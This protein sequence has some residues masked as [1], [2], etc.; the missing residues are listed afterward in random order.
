[1]KPRT[2]AL[3]IKYPA[4]TVALKALLIAIAFLFIGLVSNASARGISSSMDKDSN[5][6]AGNY[7]VVAYGCNGANDPTAV[8]FLQR[9]DSP[10]RFS[11]IEP[12]ADVQTVAGLTEDEAFRRAEDFVTCNPN[13]DD[14][15]LARITAPDGTLIGYE[16]TPVYVPLHAGSSEGVQTAYRVDGNNIRTY[17]TIDPLLQLN[18]MGGG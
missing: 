14:V 16:V 6:L 2:L 15:E 9:E 4:K 11:I 3:T 17:L 1:M 8:A 5:I 12:R 7:S 10:Y 13:A 18:Q